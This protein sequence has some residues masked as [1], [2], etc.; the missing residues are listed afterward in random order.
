MYHDEEG[1]YCG[2]YW[3][4]TDCMPEDESNELHEYGYTPFL[5]FFGDNP[6]S[7]LPYFG[8][9]LETD[10]SELDVRAAYVSDLMQLPQAGAFWLTQDGSLNNGVEVTSMP[11]TL[12]YHVTSGLWEAVRDTAAAHG[13]RSHDT[14]TCGLH[15]HVNRGFF[16]KSGLVQDACAYKLTRLMQRF[17]RQ[18]TTFARRIDNHWCTYGTTTDYAK[19]PAKNDS[20]LSK[21]A[22]L[23]YYH[24]RTHAKALNLQ[25]S[26][27]F[28]FRIFKGTL[29]VETLYASLALVNGLV[30]AVKTH[31]ETWC[32][33]VTWYDLIAAIVEAN[34]NETAR[35]C[36]T[37]YLSDKGLN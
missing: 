6:Y 36:L 27:T 3:Y 10:T 19:A 30:H 33:N 4:C 8:V 16:G 1:G 23:K 5:T 12:D 20:I 9:E 13:Y 15:I 26:Q 28:E 21:A 2:D 14:S 11:C 22:D 24:G 34:D 35:N 32:E 17:E 7:V 18:L 31:G 25:H 29:R 37:A